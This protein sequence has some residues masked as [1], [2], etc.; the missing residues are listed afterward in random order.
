MSSIVLLPVVIPAA[1]AAW[2]L[3][4]AAATAAAGALGYAAA[5]KIEEDVEVD[6][7]EPLQTV[8]IAMA[9]AEGVAANLARGQELV[10]THDDVRIV[11]SRDAAGRSALRVCGQGHTDAELRQIGQTFANRVV[12]QYAY[13]RIVTELKQRNGTIVDQQVEQDGTVRL[14]VRIFQG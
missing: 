4:A 12:Q 10:F 5:A 9:K 13:H 6:T 11:F 7:E 1:A 14:H 2:P 3:V 8:E